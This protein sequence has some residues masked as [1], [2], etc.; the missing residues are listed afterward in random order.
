M[1]PIIFYIL[2]K[3]VKKNCHKERV[4]YFNEWSKIIEELSETQFHEHFRMSK[5]QFS[6]IERNFVYH[7]KNIGQEEFRLRL[8]VIL[9]YINHKVACLMIRGLF[10]LPFSS[11]SRE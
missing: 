6:E 3:K 4:C 8:L 2:F 10:G 9:I 5:I 7:T 1:N 11:A